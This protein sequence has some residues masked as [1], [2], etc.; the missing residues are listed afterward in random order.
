MSPNGFKFGSPNLEWLGAIIQ[1]KSVIYTDR[2]R[3]EVGAGRMA[4][5]DDK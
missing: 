4:Y 5:G 2:I 3:K 1:G